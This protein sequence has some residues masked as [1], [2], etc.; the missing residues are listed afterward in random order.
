[1]DGRRDSGL[2]DALPMIETVTGAL[3]S[4]W[5]GKPISD[6]NMI[7]IGDKS[8]VFWKFTFISAEPESLLPSS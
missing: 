8:M 4:T 3:T 6:G 1:M 2:K 7:C 5:T